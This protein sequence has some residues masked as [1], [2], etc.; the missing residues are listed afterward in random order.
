MPLDFLINGEE[1]RYIPTKNFQSFK[2]TKHSHNRNYGL[3]K[4]IN[5]LLVE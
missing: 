3:V 5:K 1:K 2:I 4:P